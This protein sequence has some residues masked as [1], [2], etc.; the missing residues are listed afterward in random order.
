MLQAILASSKADSAEAW[1]ET[2]MVLCLDLRKAYDM[3]D[4]NFMQ[5]VLRRYS[6]S[7]KFIRVIQALH[8]GTTARFLV[9]GKTSQGWVVNSGI[10]QGYLCSS[11]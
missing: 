8:A 6:F 9:N 11:F 5:Q 4:R 3:L 2:A 1:T 10:R 7:T